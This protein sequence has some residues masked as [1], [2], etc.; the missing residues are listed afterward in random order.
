MA[1]GYETY[2][3]DGSVQMNDLSVNGVFIE[4]LTIDGVNNTSSKSYSMI[5]A[6]ELR[7]YNIGSPGHN[8][9]VDSDGSGYARLNWS[10]GGNVNGGST[11]TVMVFAR[12]LNPAGTYGI[13]INNASGQ[14]IADYTYPVPQY[15]ATIT[16]PAQANT[17]A[18]C[19][20][21][22]QM[23]SHSTSVSGIR[24]GS[25]KIILVNAPDN[26]A[27]T[28]YSYP[29]PFAGTSGT[30]DVTLRIFAPNN[31]AYVV[32]TLHV[33]AIDGPVSAGSGYG[34]Q[35]FK[36][37]QSLVY[38]SSYENMY[39]TDS[40]SVKY[41]D[42]P[43]DVTYTS[44]V[45]AITGI[46]VPFYEA[47]TYTTVSGGFNKNDLYGAVRRIGNS[48]VFRQL[49]WRSTFVTT[50]LA[51]NN[52]PYNTNTYCVVTDIGHVAYGTAGGTP[53]VIPPSTYPSYSNPPYAYIYQENAVAGYYVGPNGTTAGPWYNGSGDP[54]LYEVM[55]TGPYTPASGY[56]LRDTW[57]SLDSMRT[58]A[59][60]PPTPSGASRTANMT[61][62]IRIKSSQ[63]VVVNSSFDLE[64]KRNL[65]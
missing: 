61:Y 36:A 63:Q 41:V 22:Y 26:G 30:V 25:N 48:F 27:S 44:Q 58:W 60:S 1:F 15:A 2:R 42:Y 10:W 55:A 18:Q 65:N 59:I 28:W 62:Q 12:K 23:H 56:A 9:V 35:L 4:I 33:Y 39:A 52:S 40:L 37:D 51:P 11:T 38:D 50:A 24:P 13:Q 49:I 54:N 43:G 6:G 3:T 64:A 14:V 19:P 32:P 46:L 7:Y 45:S 29:T 16:L 8:I 53:A 17:S 47:T 34:I 20:D 5:P 57:Y 21:G 31:T